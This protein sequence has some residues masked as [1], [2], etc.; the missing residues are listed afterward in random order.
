MGVLTTTYHVPT[1]IKDR[2]CENPDLLYQLF[3]PEDR[4]EGGASPEEV[5]LAAD[6]EPKQ[7]G[8][9][10]MWEDYLGLY[11][12]IDRKD[13]A[14]ALESQVTEVDH[15]GAW[16]RYWSP[17]QLQRIVEMMNAFSAEELRQQCQATENLTNYNG[18]PYEDFM[19]KIMA[20]IHGNFREFVRTIS[21]GGDFMFAITQ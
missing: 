21:S 5:G 10:K 18:E 15:G 19:L 13:L 17:E 4:E 20:R 8:F 9:D 16:T 11:N 3:Y 12:Q 6:W 1:S 14:Y 2:V 7:F